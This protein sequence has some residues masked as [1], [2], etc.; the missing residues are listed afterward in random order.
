MIAVF[1]ILFANAG[2]VEPV[3]TPAGTPEHYGRTFDVNARGVFFAVQ[4]ALPLMKDGGSIILTGSGVWQK[5][6]PIYATYAATK[7]A[8]RSFARTWTAEF[9]GNGIRTNLINF[10]R[11][12]PPVNVHRSPALT[13]VLIFATSIYFPCAVSIGHAEEKTDVANANEG[14]ALVVPGRSCHPNGVVWSSARNHKD[15]T[16]GA[17]LRVHRKPFPLLCV[18]NHGSRLRKN[19]P[20]PIENSARDLRFSLYVRVTV[21]SLPPFTRRPYSPVGYGLISSTNEAFTRTER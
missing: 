16:D 4:T 20:V 8:L 10:I 2:V 21:Y 9:A 14:P 19:P 5:S 7:A 1:T 11:P 13:F 6:I 18:G 12:P 15:Q 3:P 17:W